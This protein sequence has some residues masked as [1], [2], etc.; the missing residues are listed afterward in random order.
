[1][2]PLLSCELALDHTVFVSNA[3]RLSVALP[4]SGKIMAF[5]SSRADFGDDSNDAQ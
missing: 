4:T 1:M 3:L 2:T 5:Q